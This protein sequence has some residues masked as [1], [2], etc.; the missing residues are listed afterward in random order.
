[1]VSDFL[2]AAGLVGLTPAITARA[3]AGAD[4]RTCLYFL[5]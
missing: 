2:R 1:M 3:H 5:A 4:E